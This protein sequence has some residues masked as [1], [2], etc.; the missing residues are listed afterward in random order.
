MKSFSELC[1][2]FSVT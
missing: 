2:D 1:T